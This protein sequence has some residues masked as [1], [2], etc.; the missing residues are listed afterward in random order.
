MPDASK[1]VDV[2]SKVQ[3]SKDVVNI[4][5]T[6]TSEKVSITCA[7]GS[8]FFADHLIFTGS[9]GVLKDRHQSLFTP[10]LPENKVKAINS[11]GYGTLGKIFLIFE[12]PFW[13][14]QLGEFVWYKVLWTDEDLEMVRRTDREWLVCSRFTDQ[15][16]HRFDI[17]DINLILDHFFIRLT[18]LS[19]FVGVD[20][21]PNILEV[22]VTGKAI[23]QFEEIS[24]SK[25]ID[26]CM[27]LLE[28]FLEKPLPRPIE[29]KRTQW[30]TNRNFLGSYSYL[31]IASEKA[32]ATPNDLAQSLMNSHNKPIVFFAGEATHET[33]SSY[34]HG[35]ILSG[36]RAADE[37]IGSL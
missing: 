2:Q 34:S 35:A 4:N 9:L 27:W 18:G 14:T 20:E 36:W 24:D 5:W 31:S 3:M 37:L 32:E 33:Y 30:L 26:D 15:S 17:A 21:Y 10:P 11:I 7:D 29:M 1:F 25:L 22:L 6:P 16:L 8:T 23:P 19:T 28:K 12:K 13:T